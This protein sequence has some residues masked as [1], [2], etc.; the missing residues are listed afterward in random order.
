[1]IRHQA[2]VHEIQCPAAMHEL[3]SSGSYEPHLLSLP[4]A[5][6]P[7][8]MLIVI[9]Y[10]A[11]MRG[12]PTLRGFLLANSI[13]LF[14]YT[15]VVMLS[16]SIR[17]EA[18]AE[19]LFRVAGSFIPL[20]GATS[21][22]F[23]MSLLGH[24]RRLRPILWLMVASGVGWVVLGSASKLAIDGVQRLPGFWYPH[25]GPWAWIAIIHTLAMTIPGFATMSYVALTS[26]PSHERQQLR[27]ALVANFVVYSGLVDLI[28][29]YGIGVFPVGWLLSGIGSLLVVR[30]LVVEDLL[31]V[32]AVDT[33]APLLVLYFATGV[34]LAWVALVELTERSGPEAGPLRSM[35]R[36]PVPWPLTA[37]ALILCFAAVRV[38]IATIGLVARGARSV[39]GPLDRLLAQ[40]APL[41]GR[42]PRESGMTEQR[43]PGR[44]H[45]D[46]V[47]HRDP[48]PPSGVRVP[49]SGQPAHV[50]DRHL[51]GGADEH[52][53]HRA[54]DHPPHDPAMAPVAP[55]QRELEP[56]AGRAGQRDERAREPEQLLGDRGRPDRR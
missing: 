33:T 2:I 38:S 56:G 14:P 7:A 13:S 10:T 41:V 40:L 50:V 49:E 29:A 48:R 16:P 30:A 35:T 51:G 53:Q 19:Q 12:A 28:L 15:F 43:E 26:P 34:L 11:V 18:V 6:A 1:M 55:E 22:G 21:T 17:S 5:L 4:F 20:V 23:Q 47:H 39:E 9:A 36:G 46:G 8:A 25:A 45:H 52:P 42:R 54:G 3:W 44:D 31:R 32:R 37:L 27:A 24:Y